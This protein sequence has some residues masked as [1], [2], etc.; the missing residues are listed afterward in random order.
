M[1]PPSPQEQA[2]QRRGQ[3]L[4]FVAALFTALL[5]FPLLGLVDRPVRVGGVPVLYLYLFGVWLGLLALTGWLS[6]EKK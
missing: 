1:L 4:L 2:E 5:T 6:R 3:R